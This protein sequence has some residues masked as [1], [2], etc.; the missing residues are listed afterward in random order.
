MDDDMMIEIILQDFADSFL[1]K[2]LEPAH[3]ILQVDV[4]PDHGTWTIQ[5]P[6]VSGAQIIKGSH[7]EA[8]LI[9]K[10]YLDTLQQLHQGDLSPFTAMGRARSSDPVP[11]DFIP[12]KN[13]TLTP[14]SDD[15]YKTLDFFQRFFNRSKP[16][17]ILLG[18]QHSR[19]VHGGHVVVLYYGKGFRSAWYA[20]HKGECINNLE[21]TNPFPQAFV[22]LS[23]SG[24]TQI[25]DTVLEVKAGDSYYIPPDT[26][27][28]VWTESEEHL[29]LLFL[30][31]GEKA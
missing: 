25:G 15:F 26:I 7:P 21:D 17:L 2:H 22:F 12:G 19:I 8:A 1:D 24:F 16:E 10:V 31:W 6:P 20:V 23:G 27:H 5:F 18:E 30:A 11:L 14:G 13:V 9:I 3:R 29:E 28:M 4:L